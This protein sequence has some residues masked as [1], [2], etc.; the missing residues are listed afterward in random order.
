MQKKKTNKP[1]MTPLVSPFSLYPSP[2]FTLS[3]FSRGKIARQPRLTLVSLLYSYGT[4]HNKVFFSFFDTTLKI[5]YCVASFFPDELF[6]LTAR[7]F[8]RRNVFRVYEESDTR[9]WIRWD[10][11]KWSV[12]FWISARVISDNG[13]LRCFFLLTKT[14][15]FTVFRLVFTATVGLR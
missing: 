6:I 4:V 1:D 15:Q 14:K 9:H 2:P 3:I 7:F 11:T 13:P 10:Y 5:P 12:L 8:K